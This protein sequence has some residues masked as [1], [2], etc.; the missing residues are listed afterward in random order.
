MNCY[1]KPHEQR[2]LS[3]FCGKRERKE[4]IQKGCDIFLSICY[5]PAGMSS[6]LKY[7]YIFGDV[8]ILRFTNRF[9]TEAHG[10]K[11]PC[12]QDYTTQSGGVL[13]Q[14]TKCRALS[15]ITTL[16]SVTIS[17]WIAN[18]HG[19]PIIYIL[20]INKRPEYLRMFKKGVGDSFI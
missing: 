17:W 19:K 7:I 5:M 14:L 8:I 3:V 13:G 2:I 16:P 4:G 18:I 10:G 1:L 9:A 15:T 20:Q 6:S 11:A 12:T